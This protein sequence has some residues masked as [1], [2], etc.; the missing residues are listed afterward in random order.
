V[1]AQHLGALRGIR[2]QLFRHREHTQ[3]KTKR[4]Q[5]FKAH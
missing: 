3:A 1:A 2:V 5:A 4:R